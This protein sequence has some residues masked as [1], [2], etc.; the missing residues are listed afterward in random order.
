LDLRALCDTISAIVRGRYWAVRCLVRD[1]ALAHDFAVLKL[2][3]TIVKIGEIAIQIALGTVSSLIAFLLTD[4]PAWAMASF[5]AVAGVVLA[6][7]SLYRLRTFTEVGGLAAVYSNQRKCDE[8]VARFIRESNDVSILCVSAN[9]II[10]PETE[11][12]LRRAIEDRGRTARQGESVRMLLLDPEN[13]KLIGDRARELRIDPSELRK[14]IHAASIA[15]QRITELHGT[16]IEIRY[17]QAH[18]VLRIFLFNDMAFYS[19]YTSAQRGSM[20]PMFQVKA[21][22]PVYDGLSRCVTYLWEQARRAEADTMEA[23]DS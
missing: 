2:E 20:V 17:Y 12:T 18:P 14:H 16:R 5:V 22:T 13:E 19:S 3:E 4:S 1:P 8:S 9:H 6:I 23:E 7:V 11:E 15:A 21:N 10:R